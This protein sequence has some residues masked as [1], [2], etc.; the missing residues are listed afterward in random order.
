MPN[1][2]HIHVERKSRRVL[3]P[4]VSESATRE[5]Q[6]KLLFYRF[7]SRALVATS[8]FRVP[9]AQFGP[10]VGSTAQ[11]LGSA[12]VSE[13][14]LQRGVMELLQEREEQSR[15]DRASSTDGVI[16]R[17]LLSCCHQTDPQKV[18]V[19]EIAAAAREIRRQEGE[20]LQISNEVV[21][22]VLKNLGL[23]T[24]RLSSGG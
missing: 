4:L 18:F 23:Y 21:G 10:E 2:I 14:D 8:K 12:L 20:S 11:V 5:F 17:V 15:V 19:K 16:L 7:V 24:R 22:H 3:L 13:L 1:G 6:G 9:E